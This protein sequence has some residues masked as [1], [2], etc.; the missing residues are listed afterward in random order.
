MQATRPGA[1]RQ[2]EEHESAGRHRPGHA[3]AP[4]PGRRSKHPAPLCLSLAAAL[5]AGCATSGGG[6]SV[7]DRLT[8]PE[9]DASYDVLVAEVT[10]RDGDIEAALDALERAMQKDPESAYLA[11]RASRFAA[12][13]E[14]VDRAVAYGERG[15]ELDPTDVDGRRFLGRLYLHQRRYVDVERTLRDADER[16]LDSEAALLLFQMYMERGQL[17]TA[18]TTARLLLEADPENLGAYM[19]VATVYER[20]H[21]YDD[22][23][24]ALRAGLEYHPHRFVLYSRLAR[25]R[26]AAGDRPGEIAVYREVLEHEPGHHGTLGSLAEAQIA[27]G[28]VEGAIAT[29]RILVENHPGDVQAIKRLAA[30]EFTAGEPEIA[31]QRFEA[32]MAA[33]PDRPDLAYALGQVRRAIGEPEGALLAFDLVPVGHPLHTDARMQIVTILE[34]QGEFDAALAEIEALR[35]TRDD[36]AIE[37]HAATLRARTGDLEGGV[38]LLEALLVADPGDE[39]V[40]YQIGVIYGL[41]KRTDDAIRAMERVLAEN[42]DNAHALNYIGYSL[43]ERGE[44]LD[45]AERLITRATVIA[46]EDGYIADSL[47]WVYYMR[48]RPLM[49]RGSRD[50]GLALLERAR[51]QLHLADDLTGGDPVVSEHLGDVHL[52]MDDRSGALEYYERA[53]DQKYRID[54]QPDLLEK[55]DRLRTD[56][57][58]AGTG[59]GRSEPSAP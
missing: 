35:A 27:T 20:L 9:A 57:E 29:Y 43:A 18:L 54:E 59:A 40:L 41:A 23:E 8:R 10:A 48:A 34:D 7:P 52:L 50:D 39:E 11:Y 55:L 38:A 14:E 58:D 3:E 1:M 12:Q 42:P 30:L 53:V 33:H 13:I 49:E 26:R 32:A 4:R 36:R 37:F 17:S 24:A 45:R 25:V 15:M 16:P 5:L 19:A 22:A 21:E 2:S 28:D 56:L 46:P 31:A 44:D 51:E 6:S 47:G